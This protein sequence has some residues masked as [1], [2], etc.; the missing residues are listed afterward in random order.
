MRKKDRLKQ[1]LV[2][3]EVA[4]VDPSTRDRIALALAPVSPAYLR[5]L[6]REAGLPL[7][8]LVE[9]VRQ[10]SLDEAERTLCGL[11]EAYKNEPKQARR[12]VVQAKDHARLA[13]HGD[14]TAAA[15]ERRQEI[16]DWMVVWVHDPPL[17]P[18]WVRLRREATAAATAAAT[19][20]RSTPPE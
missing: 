19:E 7:D 2:D 9:G 16:I 4:R 20:S 18:T 6:L 10:E 1:W 12:L 13:L 17:F 11:S 14:R 5:K 8:P 3:A 15:R